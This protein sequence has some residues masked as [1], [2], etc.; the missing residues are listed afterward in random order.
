MIKEELLQL[1]QFKDLLINLVFRD[2]T[3]RYKRSVIGFCWTMVNPL[4]NTIIFTIV[5]ATIFRFSAE[6]FIIYFLSAFQLWILF[7][8]S[9]TLSSRCILSNG[10]LLKKVYLP[11][12]IFVISI[13]VSELVNFSFAMVPLIALIIIIGKGLSFYLLFLPIPLIIMIVFTLGVSFMLSS[14]TVFFHDIMDIYQLLLMPW[15]YFT[16]IFYP[17]EIIPAKYLFIFKINPMYY[18]IDCFRAPIYL[19]QLPDPLNV[20]W[21]GLSAIVAFIVGIILFTKLSDKFIYYI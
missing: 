10:S 21:A 15:M 4:I 13:L 2:L 18:I 20:L 14:I 3:V 1:L 8:Q 19:G 9:T 12:T 11:K 17:L 7:S 16:P 6:D 5:F